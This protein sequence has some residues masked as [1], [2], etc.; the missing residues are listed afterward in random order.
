MHR[1]CTLEFLHPFIGVQA[2]LVGRGHEFC[3]FVIRILFHRSR[4]L[5]LFVVVLPLSD[6]LGLLLLL[7]PEIMKTLG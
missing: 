7:R 6:A 4:C 2:A 5:L 1:F 3:D